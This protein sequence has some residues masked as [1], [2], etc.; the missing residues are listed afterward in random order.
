M[1]QYLAIVCSSLWQLGSQDMESLQHIPSSHEWAQG[2][3]Q[4]GTLEISGDSQLM[5]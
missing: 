3:L 4:A 2:H 1:G 5:F